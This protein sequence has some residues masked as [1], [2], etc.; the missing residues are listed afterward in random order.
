M[1]TGARQISTMCQLNISRTLKVSSCQLKRF[2]ADAYTKKMIGYLC[3][4][5]NVS[6]T[7]KDEQGKESIDQKQNATETT[8]EANSPFK[9]E[10]AA[11]PPSKKL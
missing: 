2:S 10:P 4:S 9:Q 7:T 5:K 1:K 8:L 6:G 3:E 11:F